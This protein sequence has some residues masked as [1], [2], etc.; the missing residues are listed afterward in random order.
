MI[1]PN[2]QNLNPSEPSGPTS[3]GRVP[4]NVPS[5]GS[6][7]HLPVPLNGTIER[8][9]L[10]PALPPALSPTMTPQSLL[11]A[12]RRR[13]GRAVILG[14]LFATAAAIGAFVAMPRSKY[15]ARVVFQLMPVE[16][17]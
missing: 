11:K 4:A 2:L 6:G 14:L 8:P 1:P 5:N 12:F 17:Y 15:T 7:V 16:P 9:P 10:P 3:S 13:W